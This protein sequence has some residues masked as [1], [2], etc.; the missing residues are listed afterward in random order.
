MLK[1]HI[2]QF[3]YET[4]LKTHCRFKYY[5]VYVML[6]GYISNVFRC[7]KMDIRNYIIIKISTFKRNEIFIITYEEE[8]GFI[9]FIVIWR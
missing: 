5:F 4:K 9:I 7:H 3:S 1:Y 2:W 8:K 6:D